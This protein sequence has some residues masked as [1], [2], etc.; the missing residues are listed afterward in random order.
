M[1]K[2][3]KETENHGPYYNHCPSCQNKNLTFFQH[4]KENDAVKIITLIQEDKLKSA[5]KS[6]Y[7]KAKILNKYNVKS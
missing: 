1:N 3:L 4:L 7:L 5:N 6:L 2:M